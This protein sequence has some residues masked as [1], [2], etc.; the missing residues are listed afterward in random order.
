MR[1]L[2]DTEAGALAIDFEEPA[3]QARY[4]DELGR[5]LVVAV[6]EGGRAVSVEVLDPGD[7]LDEL[8]GLAAERYG[9]DAGALR[10]A[11]RSALAV[12]DREVTLDVARSAA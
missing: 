9:L 4:G 6:A 10:A 5:G 7:E 12:P 11:A 2:Y 1:A 3:G 8:L